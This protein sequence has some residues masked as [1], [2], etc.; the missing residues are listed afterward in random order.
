M[1]VLMFWSLLLLSTDLPTFLKA[2]S[3]RLEYESSWIGNSYPGGQ[4]WVP[5]D[6][7][8]IFVTADGTV[9]SNVHWEEGGGNVTAFKDGEVLGPARRTHGWGNQGGYAVAANDSICTSAGA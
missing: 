1:K 8:H 3:P 9:Y 4:R 5:Q 7:D 2:S 6:I